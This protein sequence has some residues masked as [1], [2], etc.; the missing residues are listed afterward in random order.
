MVLI[1]ARRWPDWPL[2]GEVEGGRTVVEDWETGVSKDTHLEGGGRRG[3]LTFG[4]S[5]EPSIWKGA[6]EKAQ[7]NGRVIIVYE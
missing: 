2:N 6:R 1:R 5:R 7:V 3:R 4:S